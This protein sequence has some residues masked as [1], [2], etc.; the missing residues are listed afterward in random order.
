MFQEPTRLLDTWIYTSGQYYAMHDSCREAIRLT[1]SIKSKTVAY[2][3]N[4][5]ATL[6]SGGLDIEITKKR[7]DAEGS[8]Y[9]SSRLVISYFTHLDCF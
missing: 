4:S 9:R 5:L 6:L 2:L 8:E 3:C 7:S 1:R